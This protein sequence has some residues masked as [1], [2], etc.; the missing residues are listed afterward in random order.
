MLAENQSRLNLKCSTL[1][2]GLLFLNMNI[3]SLS[4]KFDKLTNF[5]GQLRVKFPIIGISETWLD[6][7]YHFSNIA[8][9]N[10]LHKPRTRGTFW[11]VPTRRIRLSFVKCAYSDLRDIYIY[12]YFFFHNDRD[13]RWILL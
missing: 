4:N 3:R 13:L 11:Q 12:I 6:D 5:L 1:E 7:C 9:Y 2:T 10:F 8:G